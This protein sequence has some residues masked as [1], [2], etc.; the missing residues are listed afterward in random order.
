MIFRADKD[1]HTR[2]HLD[3]VELSELSSVMV[4]DY[5]LA[6]SLPEPVQVLARPN[7]RSKAPAGDEAVVR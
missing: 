3:N 5:G 1:F 7:R 6:Q 4:V 2:K